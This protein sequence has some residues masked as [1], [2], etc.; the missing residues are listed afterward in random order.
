LAQA[1]GIKERRR[2]RKGNNAG[3][4]TGSSL[5]R[6]TPIRKRGDAVVLQND[7][8]KKNTVHAGDRGLFVAVTSLLKN[9]GATFEAMG[10]GG[11]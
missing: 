7:I 8:L 2:P 3:I 9:K 6:E 4:A 1:L 11:G 5:L 10:K